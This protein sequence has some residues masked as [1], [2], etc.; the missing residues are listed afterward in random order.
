[1]CLRKRS[2]YRPPD[3]INAKIY[4]GPIPAERGGEL[5][6]GGGCSETSALSGAG[7][8]RGLT[9][10]QNS[11]RPNACCFCWCCCCSCSCLTVRNEEERRKRR[12][13]KR[14]SQDTK[15]ET[16]LET[17]PKPLV[18]E[19]QMWSQSFD[20]L[21]RN[22]AGRNVFREFLRTEYSEE[23]MLFWLACE[24]LK[25]EINKSAIEEKARSIYEDYI[26]ILSPKEVS[27]DARVREVIN[28]KMQ[29]PTPH[30][31]EDAQLQIYTLMHRDSYPRF[32]SSNIYRTL[33]QGGSRTSSE[34]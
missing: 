22:P 17:C 3:L 34:S 13:R 9:T 32:L 29:D 14:I 19:I 15:M 20:K 4:T 12:R 16:K 25:Q 8:A 21:M 2:G 31:F 23:N 27:L 6:M 5:A 1:M 30:T 24:D 33:V 26:S 28:K 10:T 11:Q 7:E 18:E